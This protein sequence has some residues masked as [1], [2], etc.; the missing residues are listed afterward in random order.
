[1]FGADSTVSI[2]VVVS[3]LRVSKRTSCLARGRI[4][5]PVLSAG[6]ARSGQPP[7][8]QRTGEGGCTFWCF[9]KKERLGDGF[10]LRRTPSDAAR[11]EFRYHHVEEGRAGTRAFGGGDGGTAA[12]ND[13]AWFLED[14]D[15]AFVWLHLLFCRL[16]GGFYEVERRS[17][18]ARW[19][20]F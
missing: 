4:A 11:F 16:W 3:L 5:P 12:G 8:N 10:L 15:G 1:M 6:Q 2:A 7:K 19:N 17:E 14:C 9:L 20:V 18:N 13:G